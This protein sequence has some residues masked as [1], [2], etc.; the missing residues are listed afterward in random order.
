MEVVQ[1]VDRHKSKRRHLHLFIFL[2]FVVILLFLI[3][4]SFFDFFSFTG[5]II[6]NT[7]S[8]NND[9]INIEAVLT[10]PNLEIK[11]EFNKVEIRGGSDSY[12]YVESEK[13]YLGNS[14]NNYIILNNYDGD[15]LF[16]SDKISGL[17]GRVSDVSI[18][19]VPVSP[20][21]KSTLKVKL[22]E[23]FNYNSLEISDG[24]FISKLIYNATGIIKINNG[25]NIFNLDNEEIEI[26]GFLGSLRV[27]RK[28]FEIN[29]KIDRLEIRG[30]GISVS[31]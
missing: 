20:E 6:K 13:F 1:F 26:R 22:D 17:N 15:I 18:N 14:Q 12:F 4:T 30:Q 28:K 25:K 10:I 19:G 3:V 5:G 31:Y 21:K 2:I 23:N 7:N 24:A 27:E 9:G 11:G 16:D 8:S 29:G